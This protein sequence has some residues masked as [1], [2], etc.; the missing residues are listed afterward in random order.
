MEIS[1]IIPVYR[2][3]SY[4]AECVDS[5]LGQNYPSFEV[6]LVDDGSP[7]RCGTIC[8]EYAR[9]DHRVKVI[10]KENGGLSDAR[11]AG[12][13]V[14][15]GDYVLFLDSDDYWK[16]SGVLGRL[17]ERISL[18]NADLLNFSY[19]KY[20]EDTGK[21]ESYFSETQAMPHPLALPEQLGWLT[22]RGLYIASACNKMIRRELLEDCASAGVFSVK[23][24][25]GAQACC[26]GRNPWILCR[27][28][29]TATAS[30]AAPSDTASG[31]RTA[32]IWR[33]R[34]WLVCACAKLLTMTT[35]KPC[36]ATPPSS[37]EPSSPIRLWLRIPRK[38]ASQTLRPMPGVCAITAAAKN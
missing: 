6:I 4:L 8:D 14:A 28:H 11:N 37:T 31:T 30:A 16:D 1:V 34:S 32:G 18:T 27:R 36:G 12:L 33:M 15:S 5:V 23:I 7:D 25:S 24:S 10:H 35:W 38:A 2:V 26:S 20:Y 29:S 13:A 22:D 21:S 17:A 9:R 19:Q 3:E